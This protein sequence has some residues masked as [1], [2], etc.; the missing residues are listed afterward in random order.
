MN[1]GSPSSAHKAHCTSNNPAFL[2]HTSLLQCM[3]RSEESGP[4]SGGQNTVQMRPVEEQRE[5]HMYLKWTYQKYSVPSETVGLP[6]E[7]QSIF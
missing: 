2:N 4:L 7:G 6:M 5:Q 3:P 1:T